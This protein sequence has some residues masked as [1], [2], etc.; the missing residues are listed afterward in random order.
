MIQ[1]PSPKLI[2]KYDRPGPRYT[3][4]PTAP[5]WSDAFR[6]ERYLEH[7]ARADG[8]QGPLSVYLHLPFCREMCRFCGCNVVATHDRSR[9]DAYLSLL[10][11]EVA[12]VA[13]RLP[14]R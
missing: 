2:Q 9:A 1:I 3:S 12:L 11:K 13:A 6:A 7:L 10:E 8:E 4:Y 5:E 14:R